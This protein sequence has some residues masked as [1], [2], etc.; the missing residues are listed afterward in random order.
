MFFWHLI[1]V[2][3]LPDV[4][5]PQYG[6]VEV[7]QSVLLEHCVSKRKKHFI[8]INDAIFC[9]NVHFCMICIYIVFSYSFACR[10]SCSRASERVGVDATRGCNAILAACTS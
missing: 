6:V 5:V 7:V 10:S 4:D 2:P 1:H 3:T 9:R 8:L